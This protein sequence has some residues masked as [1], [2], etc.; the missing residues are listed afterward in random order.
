MVVEEEEE[1]LLYVL[2]GL[3]LLGKEREV[4]YSSGN[5]KGE[6]ERG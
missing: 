3:R 4:N 1:L 5:E 6:E 2:L